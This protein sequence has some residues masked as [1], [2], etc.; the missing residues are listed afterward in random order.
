MIQIIVS[1]IEYSKTKLCILIFR[2]L[3]AS[4]YNGLQSIF[5]SMRSKGAY[6]V[7]EWSISITFV[8]FTLKYINIII[9]VNV[10]LAAGRRRKIS[11]FLMYSV[12]RTRICNSTPDMLG[13]VLQ[14][15]SVS[16][17]T[18]H[19]SV[20]ICIPLGIC[21]QKYWVLL[22]DMTDCQDNTFVNS[23]NIKWCAP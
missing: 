15:C 10:R 17:H 13:H 21:A 3:F 1:H 19:A 12:F 22:H 2:P 9:F 20:Q 11:N 5:L 14:T 23:Y 6:V 7:F 18:Q 16:T 4:A 8:I